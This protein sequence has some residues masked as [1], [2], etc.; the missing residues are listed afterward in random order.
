M[1]TEKG[2]KKRD[3]SSF[4]SRQNP[5]RKNFFFWIV[6]LG[7]PFALFLT[8]E[9]VL[10]YF[11]YGGSLDLVV[12]TT[13]GGKE[14]YTLNREIGKRYFSQ[15][16][17]AIPEAFDDL[18]QIEKRP[19][20]RRVFMLGEST[21]AG[22][23]YDYN[24]TAPRLLQDRLREA[25]PERSIEVINV[26][27]AAVN[28]YTVLDL[29]QELAGYEPD[30]FILYLGH[31][32]YY[33]AF[34]VGSTEYLG[35]W[36]TLVNLYLR[37]EKFKSFLL[38]RDG[39]TA[40]L[41]VFHESATPGDASL[42]ASMVREKSILH[43]SPEYLIARENFE[44]NLR[45]IIDV[46]R[47]SG[48]PIVLSTLTSNV[49]DQAP[50]VSSFCD[51]VS[52][53]DRRSFGKLLEE[54]IR[55]VAHRDFASAAAT[56]GEAMEID[57]CN[58]DVCFQLAATY[59]SLGEYDHAYAAYS[60]A[61][62]LDALRFRASSDYNL[63]IKAVGAETGAPV[64]DIQ[65]AFESASPHRLVGNNLMLEHLHPNFDGYF[66]LAKTY[67]NTLREQGIIASRSEWDSSISRSDEY[68]RSISGVTEFTLETAKIRTFSLTHGWPFM[69]EN[70][71]RPAFKPANAVQEMALKYA[72]K[73]I[74]WSSAHLRLA[75][76]FRENGE[77][78]RA[79]DEYFAV[80]KVAW[81]NYQPFMHMGDLARELHRPAA[82][83]SLYLKGL[84]IQENPFLNIRLGMLYFEMNRSSEAISRF[85]ATVSGGG[86]SVEVLSL[87]EKSLARYFLG[88]AYGKTG[89][90][91]LAR[92]N[93][94]LA[95]G[96]DSTNME[97]RTMLSQIHS[98]LQRSVR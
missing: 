78:S 52:E 29:I 5:G 74:A 18:F 26:G 50:L 12:R 15:E 27:L 93:L 53:S 30:A 13:V 92:M 2:T 10:R 1:S 87:K 62:D 20:T 16:G 43:G 97:A 57:S 31:N 65:S 21:M 88:A 47:Q 32:E 34:G 82:A 81:Y 91:P 68:F 33:G 42:M 86:N 58:A 35:R 4:E 77:F 90:I 59:D 38:I 89:N 76:R 41:R 11:N 64:A 37:L 17:I 71:K 22:F 9:V 51:G 46:S 23:P 8:L 45:S 7:F 63:L 25:F 60:R 49:R 48:V 44:A 24:A 98:S 56:F 66:L 94:E 85:E 79:L 61:R 6:L 19:G 95:V 69:P 75:E 39:I 72:N 28:S 73:G 67:F 14:Y 54:G 84:A 36:R 96:L 40:A 80:S 83:E 55:L 3:P 70:T